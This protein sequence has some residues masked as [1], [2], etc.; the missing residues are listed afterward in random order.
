MTNKKH[1]SPASREAAAQELETANRRSFIKTLAA[2]S[3]A[4]G[5]LAASTVAATRPNAAIAQDREAAGNL[6]AVRPRPQTATLR[7]SFNRKQEPSIDD[8]FRAIE[9]ALGETGCTK[10]GLG[11]IDVLLRLDEIINPVSHLP[12]IILEGEFTRGR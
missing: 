11:G 2:S 12:A 7:L 5:T 10:C 9:R 6:L 1:E 3:V 4:A 8:I